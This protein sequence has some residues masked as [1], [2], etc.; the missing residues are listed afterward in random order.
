MW[1][2]DP[3]AP[4]AVLTDAWFMGVRTR[5]FL[6]E[7]PSRVRLVGVHFKPWGMS[8]FV[9]VP[10]AELGDRWLSADAVWR[11]SSDRIRNQVGDLASATETLRV[12]E[13]EL[14]S[15]LAEEPSRGLDLVLHTGQRLAASHGAAQV[16]ALAGAVG[17]SGNHLATLFKARGGLF[18]PG[19]LRQG[20]QGL[21]RPYSDGVPGLAASV[22]RRA[23]IPTRQRSHAG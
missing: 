9:D 10:A 23:G 8:P 3:S 11:R 4:P 5:R 16:G 20:V 15:R 19:L 22:P 14:R 13:A 6:M 7:Y 21:H 2:G 1:D 17:V 12:L 18:P